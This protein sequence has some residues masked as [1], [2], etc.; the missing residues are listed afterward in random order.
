MK[1][2][3]YDYSAILFAIWMLLV[4]DCFQQCSNGEK[5]DAIKREIQ[6]HR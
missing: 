2:R 1:Q 3:N 4:L 5:L 6:W